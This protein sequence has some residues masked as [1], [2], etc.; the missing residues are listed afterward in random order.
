MLGHMVIFTVCVASYCDEGMHTDC[1]QFADE[2]LNTL[3]MP[4]LRELNRN[5]ARLGVCEHLAKQQ[6][7]KP[8][9]VHDPRA[10]CPLTHEHISKC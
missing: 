5:R 3:T 1:K 9:P 2:V 7:H 6:A 8:I 4:S 10:F